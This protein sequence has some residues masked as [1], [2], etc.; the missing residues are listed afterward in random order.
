MNA[1]AESNLMLD[2]YLVKHRDTVS[3][4]VTFRN[5]TLAGVRKLAGQREMEEYATEYSFTDSKVNTNNWPKTLEGVEEY[6]RTFRGVNSAPLSYLVRNQLLPT[7]EV[8]DLSN[9]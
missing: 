6:L 8:E 2:M 4:Y 7:A 3:R 9:R 5:V 1:K